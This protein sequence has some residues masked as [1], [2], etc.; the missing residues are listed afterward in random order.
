MAVVSED[1]TPSTNL[2]IDDYYEYKQVPVGEQKDDEDVVSTCCSDDYRFNPEYRKCN[3]N[4]KGGVEI[5]EHYDIHGGYE[6]QKY[7]YLPDQLVESLEIRRATERVMLNQLTE[8]K[9][10]DQTV[11]KIKGHGGDKKAQMIERMRKKLD[12]RKIKEAEKRLENK[13]CV[14]I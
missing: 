11:K 9:E 13:D 14:S 1:A 4:R 6:E 2:N 8:L 10:I 7:P 5:K 12:D 3:L